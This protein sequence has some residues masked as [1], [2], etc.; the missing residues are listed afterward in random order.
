MT[1]HPHV[2]ALLTHVEQLDVEVT[3][4]DW[5]IVRGAGRPDP[6]RIEAV[7]SWLVCEGER[8]H[9]E[10]RVRG[11]LEDAYDFTLT[12]W[13]GDRPTDE[14]IDFARYRFLHTREPKLPRDIEEREVSIVRHSFSTRSAFGPWAWERAERYQEDRHRDAV[15]ALLRELAA[16]FA[17]ADL[18][19]VMDLYA[20][21]FES[22]ARISGHELAPYLVEQRRILEGLMTSPEYRVEFQEPSVIEG[23]NRGRLIWTDTARGL[24]PIVV[25]GMDA[26]V[27]IA[28]IP[29]IVDGRAVF[30]R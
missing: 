9:V 13:R 5:P 19:R 24:P 4:N 29:S 8:N 25:Y 14:Q 1:I 10:A 2:F 6:L 17:K 26:R 21:K 20:I 3:V 27:R 7:I 22:G 15:L 11:K 23:R 28:A 16:A 18:E 12:L 30:V